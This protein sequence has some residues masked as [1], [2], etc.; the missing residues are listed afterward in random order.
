MY[1]SSEVFFRFFFFFRCWKKMNCNKSERKRGWVGFGQRK[2]NRKKNNSKKKK[3]ERKKKWIIFFF[4]F[5]QKNFFA[6][7]I[8]L[9][10]L[11]EIV[12]VE[13]I[14]KSFWRLKEGEKGKNFDKEVN[15]LT[16]YKIGGSSS[17]VPFFFVHFFFWQPN[18]EL[19]SVA[20]LELITVK[21]NTFLFLKKCQE[22]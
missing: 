5:F 2:K 12:E 18:S 10:C 7:I 1:W 20:S 22:I 9:E 16:R 3:I 11:L 13:N 14:R 4:F 17:V 19:R 8:F 15:S 6:K 21:T